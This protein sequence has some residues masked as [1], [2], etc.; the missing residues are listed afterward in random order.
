[1]KKQRE[2]PSQTTHTAATQASRKTG[3]MMN[4]PLQLSDVR[5]GFAKRADQDLLDQLRELSV[6]DRP[7]SGIPDPQQAAVIAGFMELFEPDNNAIFPHLGDFTKCFRLAHDYVLAHGRCGQRLPTRPWPFCT[8]RRIRWNHMADLTSLFNQFLQHPDVVEQPGHNGEAKAWCPWHA[9]RRDGGKPSL[10]INVQ[11]HIVH[12]FSGSCGMGGYVELAKAWNINLNG[13]A[14]P[15]ERPILRTHDYFNPA[16]GSVRFQTV[17][18]TDA[19]WSIR[20]PD[21]GKPDGWQWGLKGLTPILYR[22][23]ELRGADHDEWVIFVEGEKDVERLIALGF[24][25]TTNPMGA[26][27]WRTTYAKEFRDRKVAIIPDNDKSGLGH[28]NK[29]ASEIYGIAKIVKIFEPLPGVPEKGDVSDWLDDGHAADDLNTLIAQTPSY[30]PPLDHETSEY[31]EPEWKVNPLRDFALKITEKLLERG[32][33]VNGGAAG[34]FYF[35]RRTKELVA[36]SKDNIEL[37]SLLS[38]HYKLN[39]KDNLFGVLLEHL[40]VEAHVRGELS[41]LRTFGNYDRES[42]IAYLEMGKGRILKIT[43]DSIE[44]RDN[45]QDGVLFLPTP[46]SSLWE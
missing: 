10:G 39:P 24:V 41:E 35:D 32:F 15:W 4:Q 29:V 25:A 31:G 6:T 2:P 18:F 8:E 19:T 43:P 11:K 44:I 38:D 17:K 26:K 28:R 12:C 36:L 14:P 34:Y 40:L 5:Q 37:K 46:K 23:A 13:D 45:G 33:F 21:S 22:L 30:T 27:P 3:D 42:N 20:R 7:M 9:D 16:D 1:M